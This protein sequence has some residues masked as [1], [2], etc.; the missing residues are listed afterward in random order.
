MFFLGSHLWVRG[1][2][3]RTRPSEPAI[4]PQ[5]KGS[6][7]VFQ[8]KMLPMDRLMADIRNAHISQTQRNPPANPPSSVAFEHQFGQDSLPFIAPEEMV[9]VL[10]AVLFAPT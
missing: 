1:S 4:D 10:A 9:V 5:P 8:I 3:V 6:C 7:P 2:Q